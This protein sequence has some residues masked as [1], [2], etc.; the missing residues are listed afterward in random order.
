MRTAIYPG[1]FDPITNGHIDIIKRARPMFD[2]VIVTLAVNSEKRTLFTVEE[3]RAMIAEA[4]QGLQGVEVAQFSGLVVDFAKEVHASAIIRGLRAVS[5]FEY[6]FQ[7]ALM[8]RKQCP[9]IDT[10]F[11]MPDERYT[12]LSSSIVRELAKHQGKIDCFVPAVTLKM[13]DQKF[14]GRT[15]SPLANTSQDRAD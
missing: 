12:Y 1:T 15:F 3:R 2:R 9:T 6:E 5:D 14:G 13:L 7:M 4:T 8:N 10:V 11:L